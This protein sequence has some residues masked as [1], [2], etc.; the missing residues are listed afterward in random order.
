MRT[1]PILF[2]LRVTF[3]MLFGALLLGAVGGALYM[4][5]GPDL[6]ITL[7]DQDL[8]GPGAVV[9]GAVVGGVMALVLAMLLTLVLAIVGLV[10]PAVLCVVI[11]ALALVAV[12]LVLGA[13]GGLAAASAPFLLVGVACVLLFR[14]LTRRGPRRDRRDPQPIH[15]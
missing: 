15:L 7:G 8:S 11:V 14:A 4:A 13:L 6:N 9:L 12:G 5:F 10:I 3:Q 2:A 1:P